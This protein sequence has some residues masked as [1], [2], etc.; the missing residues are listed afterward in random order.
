MFKRRCEHEQRLLGRVLNPCDGA[1]WKEVK[2]KFKELSCEELDDLRRASQRTKGIAKSNRKAKKE[3]ALQIKMA[4][5]ADS[6]G[7]GAQEQA[8][9]IMLAPP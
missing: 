7:A 1:T 2:D 3:N 5:S 6:T 4:E 9:D 8:G